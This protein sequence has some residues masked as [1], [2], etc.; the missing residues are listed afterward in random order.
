M[1]RLLPVVRGARQG[2]GAWLVLGSL[3]LHCVEYAARFPDQFMLLPTAALNDAS[4]RRR[5]LE[6]IG[7]DA[8]GAGY[9]EFRASAT[10]KNRLKRSIGRLSSLLASNN[11]S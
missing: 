9:G 4:G 5:I 10:Y 2:E 11:Y 8:A 3:S 1:G 6:F 7:H